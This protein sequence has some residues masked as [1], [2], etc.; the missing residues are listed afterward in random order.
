MSDRGWTLLRDRAGQFPLAMGAGEDQERVDVDVVGTFDVGVETITHEDWTNGPHPLDGL[1]QQRRVG[2]AS[3]DR[4]D[5]HA[6]LDCRDL[7]PSTGRDAQVGGTVDVGVRGVPAG[8]PLNG[9]RGVFQPGECHL[10]VVALHHRIG[11]FGEVADGREAHRRHL[12]DQRLGAAHKHLGAGGQLTRHQLRDRLGAGDDVLLV[13]FDPKSVEVRDHHL[14]A[15]S[16]IVR[17]ESDAD[18][19]LAQVSDAF[20]RTD[21]GLRTEVDHP[22]QIE[23]GAVVVIDEPGHWSSSV[24]RYW[25]ASSPAGSSS[26]TSMSMTSNSSS[27][28]SSVTAT[29]SSSAM[30]SPTP[31]AS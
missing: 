13:A 1:L 12:V 30:A 25:S 9:E 31:K 26:M 6:H 21:H 18:A 10:G 11:C 24:V 4:F 7:S 29:P 20:G 28:T 23:H 14:R 16:S 5:V 2:L 27:K 15:A 8:A 17:H 22:V 3:H 19:K